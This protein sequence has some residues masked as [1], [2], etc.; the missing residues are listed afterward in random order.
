MAPQISPSAR[1]VGFWSAVLAMAFN[2]IEE[3]EKQYKG[4][5]R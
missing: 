2:F 1:A 5:H 4:I 3:T